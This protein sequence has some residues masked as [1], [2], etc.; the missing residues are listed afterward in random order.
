MAI[1]WKIIENVP[2]DEGILELRQRGERDFLITVGG[3]VL[4]SSMTH[5]TE[6]ALGHLACDRFKHHPNPRVLVGG[7]GMGYTLR[8]VLDVLPETARVHVAELNPVVLEWCRGPLAHLTDGAASAPRVAMEI[9]DVTHLIARYATAQKSKKLDAVVL[10]LYTG[11]YVR[12]HRRDDPIYGSRALKTT[13][14]A[15]KPSGVFAVWGEDYDAGFEKRL[16]STGFSVTRN[17]LKGS[18]QGHVV[19]LGTVAPRK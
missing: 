14:A 3:R 19:Y 11:P 13:R 18:G 8:A 16:R 4:M 6:D 9:A 15:L 17:R 12:T 1:P 7:L 10:D 5:R 2:T